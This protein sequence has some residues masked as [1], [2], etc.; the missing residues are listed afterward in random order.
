MLDTQVE[1]QK[2]LLD[3]CGIY[4]LKADDFIA[5]SRL[6]YTQVKQRSG[7]LNINDLSTG[8]TNTRYVKYK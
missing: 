2:D 5:E 3:S 6:T 7:M 8:D 4:T 1:S